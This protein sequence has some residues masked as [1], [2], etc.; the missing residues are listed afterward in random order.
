M[1]IIFMDGFGI[2]LILGALLE[3]VAGILIIGRKARKEN[4]M[5]KVFVV[6]V[7]II[8]VIAFLMFKRSEE[9]RVGKEC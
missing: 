7:F 2:I 9:R 8:Q 3:I 5:S 1:I 4:M 6:C